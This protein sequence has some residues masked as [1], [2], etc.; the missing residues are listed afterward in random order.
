MTA[1][2][3]A[4]AVA[5]L[6][7]PVAGDPGGP[8]VVVSA[9]PDDEVIGVGAWLAAQGTRPVSFVV[10]TD[11]EQSHPRSTTVT[12]DELRSVRRDELVVAL[13]VLGHSSPDV[14]HLGLRDADLPSDEVLLRELLTPLLADASL[15]LAP[16]ELD[17]HADH[18]TVGRVV[19]AVAPATATVWRFPVWRWVWTTPDTGRAWLD[20]AAVLPTNAAGRRLKRH[21]L[22][23]FRSQ[24]E[25]LS[26]RPGDEPVVTEHLLAHALSAPEVVIT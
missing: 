2:S 3:W 20:G 11:G 5:A 26:E 15:V 23:A 14:T 6:T 16:Y 25:P 9:H 22:R 4:D 13:R 18:D 10:A 21:A 8:A 12:P 24:L 7:L 17:G 19:R 1:G